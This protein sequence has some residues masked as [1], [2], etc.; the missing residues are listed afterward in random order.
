MV[1]LNSSDDDKEV[2]NDNPPSSNEDPTATKDADEDEQVRVVAAY[3]VYC[4]LFDIFL[5]TSPNFW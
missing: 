3:F 2:T 5:A 1:H 4:T